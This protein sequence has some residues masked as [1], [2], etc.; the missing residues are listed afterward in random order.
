MTVRV[1]PVDVG[2]IAR[3][4]QRDLVQGS[5]SEVASLYRNSDAHRP[6][7]APAAIDLE[8]EA[9]AIGMPARLID[10]FDGRSPEPMQTLGRS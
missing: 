1:R 3:L 2:A 8:I 4:R 9:T 6:P 5:Q 10:V 7:L